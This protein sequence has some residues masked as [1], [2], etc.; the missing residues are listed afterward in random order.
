MV[1]NMVGFVVVRVYGG[2]PH[3]MVNLKPDKEEGGPRLQCPIH[4]DPIL[5]LGL[6]LKV[7]LPPKIL[8]PTNRG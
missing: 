1:R 7:L 2:S 8:T 4:S 3:V 6:P 5:K